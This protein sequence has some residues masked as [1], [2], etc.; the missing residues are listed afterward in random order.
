MKQL[1][2]GFV[3]GLIAPVIGL[4]IGLQISTAVDTL[5][6]FPIIGVSTLLDVPF[7]L[8]TTAVRLGAWLFSGIV[9][10]VI[11][12]IIGLLVGRIRH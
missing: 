4:F 1:L 5:F 7:G 10:A 12:C 6:T 9:W 3:F 8:M 11:F 2:A